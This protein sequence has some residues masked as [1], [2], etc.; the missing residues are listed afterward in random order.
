MAEQ[1][2]LDIRVDVL[3]SV[4][5]NDVET[6]AAYIYEEYE[7]G[8]GDGM[9][10][11]SLTVY[12]IADEDGWYVDSWTVY[13]GGSNPAWDGLEDSLTAALT[14]A[15]ADSLWSNDV[16]VDITAMAGAVA[17]MSAGINDYVKN[18]PA[19]VSANSV[20]SVPSSASAGIDF[21]GHC[22]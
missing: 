12:A 19:D 13:V 21:N 1:H 2:G 5:T 15:F 6:S 9:D 8:M 20:V 4:G 3:T 7:Y 14:P 11:V 22:H 18:G 10:G 16:N 17:A